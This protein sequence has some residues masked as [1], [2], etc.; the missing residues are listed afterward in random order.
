MSGIVGC[1]GSFLIFEGLV[2]DPVPIDVDDVT[3]NRS[4]VVEEDDP[5]CVTDQFSQLILI[6][7]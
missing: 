5:V 3:T 6:M 2:F 7:R 1:D 4:N